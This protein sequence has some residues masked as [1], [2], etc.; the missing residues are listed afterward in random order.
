MFDGY[1]MLRF[2]NWIKSSLDKVLQF[3][4]L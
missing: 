2:L 1:F 4:S 3:V